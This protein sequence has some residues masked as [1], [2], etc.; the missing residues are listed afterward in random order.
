MPETDR[1]V[2][3]AVRAPC[4]P[5]RQASSECDSHL[6]MACYWSAR[7]GGC[8]LIRTIIT[9]VYYTKFGDSCSILFFF[10]G[11]EYNL[12]FHEG[13]G[14]SPEGNSEVTP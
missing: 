13:C 1:G 2:S 5:R 9:L 4:Q 7:I 3:T 14:R 12:P 10:P 6:A 8:G 11:E